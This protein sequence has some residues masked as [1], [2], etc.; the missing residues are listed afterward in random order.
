MAEEVTAVA[1]MAVA[2]VAAMV[3]LSLKACLDLNRRRF[4]ARVAVTA[5]VAT[6]EETVEETVEAAEGMAG[7]VEMV[8][9]AETAVLGVTAAVEMVVVGVAVEMA[10]VGR[11]AACRSLPH[12]ENRR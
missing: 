7:E 1:A 5:A 4:S 10:V 12:A 9:A 8:G 2:E 3:E 6:V 11:Y